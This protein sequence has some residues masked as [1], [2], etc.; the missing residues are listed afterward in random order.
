[1]EFLG[2]ILLLL[3]ML[4]LATETG[5]DILILLL[6]GL[7]KTLFLGA[8]ALWRGLTTGP[9]SRR[10]ILAA[11]SAA[12]IGSVVF[13]VALSCPP[14]CPDREAWEPV[15]RPPTSWVIDRFGVGHRIEEAVGENAMLIIR[16]ESG[17]GVP[18][19]F[20]SSRQEEGGCPWKVAE[21][22]SEEDQGM[23]ALDIKEGVSP[24]EGAGVIA[25]SR[26]FGLVGGTV[27]DRVVAFLMDEERW[28]H[29]HGHA[30]GP[31]VACFSGGHP[32]RCP[33]VAM[34]SMG[35]QTG[36]RDCEDDQREPHE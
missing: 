24:G 5:R 7:V 22:F 31:C 4:A 17:T 19:R 35:Q 29:L 20:A 21:V 8:R 26:L 6:V 13:G 12:A 10:L 25:F 2:S 28:A 33:S 9:R 30:E 18:R 11:T 15:Y 1:M 14:A 36:I 3:A 34:T 23:T 16:S 32:M 27:Q